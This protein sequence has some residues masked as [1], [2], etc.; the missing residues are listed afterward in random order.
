MTSENYFSDSK[1]QVFSL[2]GWDSDIRVIF[3]FTDIGSTWFKGFILD[4]A[5]LRFVRNIS[6]YIGII[7]AN[8]RVSEIPQNQ[9][10]GN[11][12]CHS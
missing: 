6:L 3:L 4:S 1:I 12:R 8:V 2:L 10:Q 5:F 11:K 9:Y 7:Y